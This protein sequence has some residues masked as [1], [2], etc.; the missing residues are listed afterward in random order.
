MPGVQVCTTTLCLLAFSVVLRIQ[1][2]VACLLN[3]HVTRWDLPRPL[4]LTHFIN[5]FQTHNMTEPYVHCQRADSLRGIVRGLGHQHKGSWLELC[6]SLGLLPGGPSP[7]HSVLNAIMLGTKHL[8]ST[9]SLQLPGLASGF[10]VAFFR[11]LPK[12]ESCVAFH[13][14]ELNKDSANLIFMA[15]IH[16]TL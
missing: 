12:E 16:V 13:L 1:T 6:R 9:G 14:K 8:S 11:N 2:K 15:C 5:N 10:H 7:E 3:M 4:M